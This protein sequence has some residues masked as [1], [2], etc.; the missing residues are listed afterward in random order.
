MELIFEATELG[1]EDKELG[2][3]SKGF[4][5]EDLPFGFQCARIV[6]ANG[7]ARLVLD[8]NCWV[9]ERESLARKPPR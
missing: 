9:R 5:F 4:S 7:L 3:E 8:S 6:L 2:F 1:L